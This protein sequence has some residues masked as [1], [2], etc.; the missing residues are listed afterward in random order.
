MLKTHLAFSHFRK[1]N[2]VASATLAGHSCFGG[3]DYFQR[4][5]VI[6]VPVESVPGYIKM[7]VEHKH[8]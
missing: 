7:R 8:D 4:L 2:R 5:L 3:T 1:T 6:A